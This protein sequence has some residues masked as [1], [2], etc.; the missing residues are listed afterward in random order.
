[1]N[2]VIAVINCQKYDQCLKNYKSLGS[3]VHGLLWLI[4]GAF[5]TCLWCFGQFTVF[6]LILVVFG[7]IWCFLISD[8]RS[9]LRVTQYNNVRNRRRHRRR[10]ALHPFLS[11]L[12]THTHLQNTRCW[13]SSGTERGTKSWT[14]M[15]VTIWRIWYMIMNLNQIFRKGFIFKPFVKLL[16]ITET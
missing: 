15:D 16:L 4:L 1:M 5:L 7:N 8:L 12:E 14:W 11:K 6:S 13:S 2:V 10:H 9:G 3:L